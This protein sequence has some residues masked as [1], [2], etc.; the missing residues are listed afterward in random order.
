M[1]VTRVEKATLGSRWQFGWGPQDVA[2]IG[3]PG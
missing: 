3:E 1:A 2:T